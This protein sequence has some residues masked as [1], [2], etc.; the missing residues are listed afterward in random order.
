MTGSVTHA[1]FCCERVYD[2]APARVFHAF[3]DAE[4]R[5]RW[6]FQ[7]D[8]WALHRHSGGETAVGAVESSAFSPPGAD[9]VITNDSVYLDVVENARLVFAYQMTI[10]G[11]R[12]SASLATAEFRAEGKG[13]RL[14]FTEQGAYFDDPGQVAGREEGTRE[15]LEA[16]A[17][18]LAG[19]V[20]IRVP[21]P[22]RTIQ[23]Y[24]REA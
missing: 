17:A 6:F 4:A 16:L 24:E 13:T 10:A 15:L 3:T 2:A 11:K 1:T 21:Q 18:E 20:R 12:I 23:S 14:V 22:D 8:A 5:R 9:M 7:A 19:R